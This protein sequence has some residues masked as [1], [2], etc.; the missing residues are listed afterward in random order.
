VLG[1]WLLFTLAGSGRAAGGGTGMEQPA[2]S[3]GAGG[4]KVL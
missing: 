3:A 4:V 1:G 2:A